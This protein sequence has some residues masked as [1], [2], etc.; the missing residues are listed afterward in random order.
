VGQRLEQER[1]AIQQTLARLREAASEIVGQRDRRRDEWQRAAVELAVTLA[2]RLV[3]DEVQGGRFAV[4]NLVKSMVEQLPPGEPVRVALHPDDLALLQSR[5]G[6]RPLTEGKEVRLA[7][8]STLG[9]ADCRVEAGDVMLVS[10][11]EVQLAEMRREL[12]RS[13]GHARV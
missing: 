3:H 4:E 2:T 11:L 5:L 1:D 6:D 13:L 9:R 8:D 12:L 7:A 10:Q